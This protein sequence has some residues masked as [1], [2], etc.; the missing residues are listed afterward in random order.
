MSLQEKTLKG[1]GRRRK[2]IARE[3]EYIDDFS[4]TRYCYSNLTQSEFIYKC[5]NPNLSL[6]RLLKH[7]ISSP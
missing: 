1:Y 3:D 6:T 2:K 5:H 7:T 4:I